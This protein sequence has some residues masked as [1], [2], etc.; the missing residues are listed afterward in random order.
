[1]ANSTQLRCAYGAA[2]DISSGEQLSKEEVPPVTEENP[3]CGGDR[4][5]NR[6]DKGDVRQHAPAVYVEADPRHRPP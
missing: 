2:C 1:M 4:G 6:L 3:G 5:R